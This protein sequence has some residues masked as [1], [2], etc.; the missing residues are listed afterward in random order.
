MVG[1]CSQFRLVGRSYVLFVLTPEA[2]VAQ[3]LNELDAWVGRTGDFFH[4]K[5]IL[6]DLARLSPGKRD[7][8]ALVADLKARNIPVVGIDGVDSSLLDPALPPMINGGRDHGPADR[9][10]TAPVD[11]PPVAT[12]DTPPAPGS[13]LLN[14]P[15]RSGQSIVFEHGD[16]TVLGSVGSGA[17]IIA[18]GSIHIY[19]TLRGR[20]L[21][22]V[23]G[24]SQ[25]RI[26]CRNFEAELVAIDGLYA[27]INDA[28][29]YLCG[30]PV[31]AWL[32]QGSLQMTELV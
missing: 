26:F 11:A 7:L 12:P 29:A 24:N 28:T 30:R 20:V 23:S 1:I 9:R 8:A 22:G 15:V 13:L 27:T 25:A 5:P 3:W 31:Q 32:D 2:P 10:D 18:G 17:E 14:E 16:V 6:L 4:R 21:A 19:G